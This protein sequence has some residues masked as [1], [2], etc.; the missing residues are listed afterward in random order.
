ML[1]YWC[2]SYTHQYLRSFATYRVPISFKYFHEL[3]NDVIWNEPVGEL[4]AGGEEK[5]CTPCF[6]FGK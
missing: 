1:I 3:K 4:R 2:C 5:S 6:K